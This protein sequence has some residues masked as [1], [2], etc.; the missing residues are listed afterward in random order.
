MQKIDKLK[1]A[2]LVCFGDVFIGDENFSWSFQKREVCSSWN[3][4]QLKIQLKTSL[5]INYGVP[6]FGGKI[7][8]F[9]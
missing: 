1:L 4:Q 6:I 9:V 2:Y 5:E 7:Y 8:N 3:C